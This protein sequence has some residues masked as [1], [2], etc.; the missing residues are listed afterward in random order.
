MKYITITAKDY[1]E[2][3][4]KAKAQYGE[5][6]CIHSM[7]DVTTRGFL[8][9]GKRSC[10]EL[11]C[12][13]AQQKRQDIAEDGMSIQQ[14]NP[15]IQKEKERID[16]GRSLLQRNDFSAAFS[17]EVIQLVQKT[18]KE[19]QSALPSLEEFELLLVDAIVSCI[20]IDYESQ[21]HP[22]RIFVLLGPTGIGKTTTIAKI[23]ALHTTQDRAD[24]QKRI[25]IITI[26]SFRLGAF[27]QIDSFGRQLGVPVDR[28]SSEE[29]FYRVLAVASQADLILVDTIGKSPKDAELTVQMQTLLS[30]LDRKESRFYLALSPLM[31]QDDLERFVDQYASFGLSGLVVTKTDES[32]TIGTIVSLSHSRHLPLLFITDGQHIPKD[33]HKACAAS[34]LSLLQGF[35]IDFTHLSHTQV[36][37]SDIKKA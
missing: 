32:E 21:L 16:H 31:K 7:R 19:K 17:E 18:L 33:I 4:R 6:L 24:K 30:V 27:E 8:G 12:Y 34:I 20:E 15:M 9:M 28:V 1:S 35:S 10:V 29:D 25:H 3:L 23:A 26:D 22:P 36:D 37:A 2:A 13:L 14:E 5:S 11:T